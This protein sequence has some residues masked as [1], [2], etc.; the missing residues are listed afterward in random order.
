MGPKYAGP[1]QVI[2]RVGEV[3]YRLRLPEGARI[4]DVFHVGVLKPFRGTPPTSEPVLPPLRHGRPLQRLERI[5]R[6]ELRRGIWH[7]LVEWSGMPASEATW[8]PVPAFREAHP[9]FQLADELFPEGG[10]DVMV[11]KTYTRRNN[12]RA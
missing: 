5:L 1:I 4:H 8:E 6:S 2:A 7:V 10:I 11:G 12:R 9:S 3:A